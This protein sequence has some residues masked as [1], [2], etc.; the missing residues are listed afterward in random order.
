[1]RKQDDFHLLTFIKEDVIGT[2]NTFYAWAVLFA[3]LGILAMGFVVSS[4]KVSFHGIAGSRETNVNFDY[5]VEVHRVLVNP[6]Q[7]VQKNE[8]LLEITAESKAKKYIFA[9]TDGIV[10]SVNFNKGEKAPAFSSLVTVSPE[11]PTYVQGFVHEALNSDLDVGSPVT[12][13]SLTG[14]RGSVKGRVAGVGGRIVPMPE[15]FNSNGMAGKLFYGREVLVEIES[16]NKLLLGERVVIS[17]DTYWLQSFVAKADPSVARRV[18]PATT[19]SQPQQVKVAPGLRNLVHLEL[20][21]AS[22][23]EDMKKYLVVSDDPGKKNP[24]YLFLLND[25]GE[26]EEPP[27]PI[28]GVKK[29]KDAESISSEGEYSYVMSSLWAKGHERKEAGSQFIRFRRKGLEF[30]ATE[31][32]D[33]AGIL[34]KLLFASRDPVVLELMRHKDR[35]I[36]VEAHAVLQGDL[37]LALKAPLLDNDDSVILRIRDVSRLFEKN[38]ADST[39]EPWKKLRF[40]E[41]GHR[42][43]DLVFAHGTIYMTTTRKKQ[44]GGSLW[45][46]GHADVTPKLVRQ[47][48]SLRPE[49]VAYNP[50][51]QLLLVTF[52]GGNEQPSHYLF[53]GVPGQSERN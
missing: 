15:R 16:N 6:G 8:L 30:S 3:V 45:K 31:V 32:I 43:S 35:P 51:K 29:M 19:M 18:N 36:E 12:V 46:L 25:D 4:P 22:Y 7:K 47:F 50:Q 34:R 23:M 11:G 33:F 40:S 27:L 26:V 13:S 41:E 17:P 42:V 1:M 38:G 44:D 2:E 37:Y 9:E 5:P 49:G 14:N 20:S 10:G 52:D 21:G 53:V 48:P 39:I 28:P 24:P